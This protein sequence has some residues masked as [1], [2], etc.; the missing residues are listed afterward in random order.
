MYWNGVKPMEWCQEPSAICEANIP[1]RSHH[2]LKGC[3]KR[4]IAIL[5][6]LST[7]GSHRLWQASRIASA[8]GWWISRGNPEAG[9]DSSAL[10]MT[11]CASPV[12]R[13]L[14]MTWYVT[15]ETRPQKTIWGQ[16][17]CS[18]IF[19]VVNHLHMG[20]LLSCFIIN[21]QNVYLNILYT[22]KHTKKNM[23]V[24]IYL[25]HE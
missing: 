11:T 18:V 15:A 17:W 25:K 8:L 24:Y 1:G 3:T 10:H 13:L 2:V 23:D 12:R 14:H 5:S 20:N 21:Q 6:D 19:F 9:G 4:W 16:F 7:Q 22:H